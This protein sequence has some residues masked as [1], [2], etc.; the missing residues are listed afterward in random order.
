[1]NH[2]AIRCRR[3]YLRFGLAVYGVLLGMSGAAGAEEFSGKVLRGIHRL[4]LS[5]EGIPAKFERYGLTEDELRRQAE[6]RLSS[7]GIEVIGLDAARADRRAGQMRIKLSANEDSF[8]F[9]F[10]GLSVQ[11]K[12]KIPLD[13]DGLS[14]TS[15]LIWS[16]AR[17]GVVKPSELK[18]VYTWVDTIMDAFIAEHR[19]HNRHSLGGRAPR[20]RQQADLFVCRG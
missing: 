7:Q 11:V 1:M 14:F 9:Y 3:G 4:H 12:R 8:A 17:N 5:I 15:Q 19:A 18:A 13:T 16:K 10:Y 2:P 6:T 20:C